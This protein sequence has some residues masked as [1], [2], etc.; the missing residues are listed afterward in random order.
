VYSSNGS[1]MVNCGVYLYTV[2][3]MYKEPLFKD[4]GEKY[5]RILALSKDDN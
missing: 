4:F 1:L 2:S 3:E 5:A